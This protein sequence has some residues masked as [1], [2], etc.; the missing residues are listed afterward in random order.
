MKETLQAWHPTRDQWNHAAVLH[1]FRRA[2]FGATP[3]ELET[4]LEEGL[5]PTLQRLFEDR[6]P[7]ASHDA[8]QPL[9][10]AESLELLQSWWMSLIVGGTAPLRER[11]SLVWHDL[12]ATSHEKVGDVRL[13]HSQNELL[14]QHGL[15]DF[16]LLFQAI[17]RDPAMLVWLDGN[18]NRSGHPNENFAREVMELFAL[19]KGH[20]QERDIQEAARAFSGWGTRGRS[21]V[22]VPAHHDGGPKTLF[23][24]TGPWDGE[25]AIDLILAQ[26]ACARHIA[27]VLLEAFVAPVV[28]ARWRE[29]VAATLL[30]CNWDIAR[31]MG[32]LLRSELFFSPAARRARIAAPVELLV[33]ASRACG[34]R[35]EPGVLAHH[36]SK[37]GQSLFRPPSVKGWEGGRSWVHSGNWI[38]RHNALVE[39]AST[40]VQA[41]VGQDIL[42]QT[43]PEEP[44]LLRNALERLGSSESEQASSTALALVFTSPEFQLF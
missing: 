11:M 19:G 13:M 40:A 28:E 18:S 39:L 1:L 37:M 12:F 35:M 15:G 6:T 9:L 38:A 4:A 24:R 31:T 23:G 14:R 26:P 32:I 27:G 36:A 29:A 3:A 42:I 2:G 10:A 16:R 7:I 44:P 34:G 30:E 17:A 33:V 21:F 43:L 41:V 8:I 20:Y 5:E 25:A 22:H